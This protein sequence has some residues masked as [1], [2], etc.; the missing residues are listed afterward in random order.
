MLGRT[1][2]R[3]NCYSGECRLGATTM[4]NTKVCNRERRKALDVE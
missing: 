2:N 3:C 4:A 1:C